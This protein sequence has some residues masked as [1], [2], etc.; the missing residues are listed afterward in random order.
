MSQ[1]NGMQ[2]NL[3]HPLP[4]TLLSPFFSFSLSVSL[5]SASFTFKFQANKITTIVLHLPTLSC[6][7][8]PLPPFPP[9][10]ACFYKR[11]FNWWAVLPFNYLGR[12]IF[13]SCCRK[14]PFFKVSISSLLAR[15]NLQH[16][17]NSRAKSMNPKLTWP[18][19]YFPHQ[20]VFLPTPLS[21]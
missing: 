9:P 3:S 21:R 2:L 18:G 12:C 17:A 13:C 5:S 10:S 1:R 11:I 15:C 8:L 19:Q 14:P 4:H 16:H 20:L 7:V 6:C